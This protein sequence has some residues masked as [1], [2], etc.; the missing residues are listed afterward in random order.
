[1]KLKLIKS[2]YAVLGFSLLMIDAGCVMAAPGN[3]LGQ[4]GNKYRIMH[5]PIVALLQTVKAI[6]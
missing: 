5:V 2:T 1:M 3:I 4:H 6:L